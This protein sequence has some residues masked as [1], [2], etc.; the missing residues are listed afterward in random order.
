MPTLLINTVQSTQEGVY[1]LVATN[2]DGSTSSRSAALTIR[3]D[4]PPNIT[5]TLALNSVAS[6]FLPEGGFLRLVATID[7]PG[8]KPAALGWVI[9]LPDGFWFDEVVSGEVT[10]TPRRGATGELGFAYI[11][12]PTDQA[13]FTFKVGYPAGLTGS[14]TIDALAVFRSPTVDRLVDPL[15]LSINLPPT[16]LTQPVA[17]AGLPAGEV[18]FTVRASG[19]GPF[20]YQWRHDGVDIPGATEP[21]LLLTDLQPSDQGAYTVLISQPGGWILSNPVMLALFGLA[22][23]HAVESEPFTPGEIIIVTNE[24]AFDTPIDELVWSVLLPANTNGGA[25]TFVAS[26]GPSSIADPIEGQSDLLEWKWGSVAASPLTFSYEL[27]SPVDATETV[28]LVAMV[29]A[30]FG[31]AEVEITAKPDPLTLPMEQS[32]HSADMDRNNRL[33]LSELLRVI[34]LY[35]TRRGTTRTGRYR[36][37]ST[38]PDGFEADPDTPSGSAIEFSRFHSADY[39]RNGEFSLSELLRVIELYNFREGTTRT[40]AYVPDPASVDGFTPGPF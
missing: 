39:S 29:T 3:Q 36:L 28:E 2:S 15:A 19:E 7:Y 38:S 31:D 35:N 14:P 23:Q 10:I 18:V 16:I 25:W 24:L 4:S 8:L 37:N 30:T 40:G 34:E 13:S 20:T 21:S 12:N 6:T 11:E 32:F 33:D 22:A 1:H 5:A 17:Q 26:S 9:N 27:R